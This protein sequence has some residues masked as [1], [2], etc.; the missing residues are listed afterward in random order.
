MP[1][2][3]QVE[4]V[5]STY[6]SLTGYEPRDLKWYIAYTALQM[7]IVFLRTGQ[8]SVRFGEREPPDN[9]D[10]L[11]MHAPILNSLITG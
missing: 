9:A 2:F 11:L 8:R 1:D 10:E 5:A 6:E 4:E 3:L 7:G